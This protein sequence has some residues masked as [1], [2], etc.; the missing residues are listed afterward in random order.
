MITCYPKLTVSN[1]SKTPIVP[2]G[3]NKASIAFI[4]KEIFSFVIETFGKSCTSIITPIQIR[5]M[6]GIQYHISHYCY[7]CI[8]YITLGSFGYAAIAVP[9]PRFTHRCW[10]HKRATP[11]ENRMLATDGI[12]IRMNLPKSQSLSEWS[13]MA[14][15]GY[16]VAESLLRA[17]ESVLC[18][19]LQFGATSK[20]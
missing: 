11:A 5:N 17:P 20:V 14:M 2:L 15:Y 18:S 9:T 6:L 10:R 1:N 13:A 4:S 19:G 3:T 16:I 8:N 12:Q 7:V